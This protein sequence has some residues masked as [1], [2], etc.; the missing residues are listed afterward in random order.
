M[1]GT[2]GSVDFDV[3]VSYR[4]TEPDQSWVRDQLVP[5]LKAAGLKVF[6]DVIDFV[7]GRDL[8]LEMTRAGGTS[9]HALCI[10]SPDYFSGNRMVHFE[11]LG[12]LRRDPSGQESRL[13]PFIFRP[14]TL[15]DW[16]R[17]RIAVDWTDP[18]GRTREWRRL[19]RALGAPGDSYSPDAQ[20]GEDL[21]FVADSSGQMPRIGTLAIG[22]DAEIQWLHSAWKD[23]KVG[24]AALIAP[25]GVGKTT[26]A[27]N[28]WLQLKAQF[29]ELH[30][31][32]FSFYEQG[33]VAGS[34]ASAEPFFSRAF[35]DWFKIERP[36]SIWAQGKVLA[37]LVRSEKVVLILDGLEPLQHSRDPHFGYFADERLVA[38]LQ[39][40]C[41]SGSEGLCICTSRL[42]LNNLKNYADHGYR[43]QDLRNLSPYHGAELLRRF[44]IQGTDSDLQ[45]ASKAFGNHALSLSLI[46]RYIGEYHTDRD[47]RRIDTIQYLTSLPIEEEGGHAQRILSHYEAIFPA[48]TP[49]SAL[50]RCIGLFDRAVTASSLDALRQPPPIAG[51]T[52]SLVNL[53]EVDQISALRKLKRM[54]LI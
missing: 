53:S 39:E 28:W 24:V 37:E 35:S 30:V 46:G 16:F 50:L 21:P 8:M 45:G 32:R 17:G 20:K 41:I 10:L 42:P 54:G 12:A 14:T 6:L 26:V 36:T 13:I 4:W 31:E 23:V 15:P 40:L 49:E 25:G 18:G 22:R 38:F 27:W 47:I 51:L 5:A 11:S 1:E 44:A 7:P 9:R 19:L 3:F 48:H 52:E 29:P 34:Q 2:N 43:P 33:A